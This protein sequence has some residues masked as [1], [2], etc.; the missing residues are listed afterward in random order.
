[1]AG[2]N[3]LSTA[4]YTST[5]ETLAA[6]LD[7]PLWVTSSR[8]NQT[9]DQP[10]RAAITSDDESADESNAA[11]DTG[12]RHRNK[13]LLSLIDIPHYEKVDHIHIFQG[14]RTEPIDLRQGIRSPQKNEVPSRLNYLQGRRSSKSVNVAEDLRIPGGSLNGGSRIGK[15]MDGAPSLEIKKPVDLATVRLRRRGC[16][17]ALGTGL[18][19]TSN[20]LVKAGNGLKYF[21]TLTAGQKLRLIKTKF[22]NG[23]KNTANAAGRGIAFVGRKTKQG[24]MLV[25]HGTKKGIIATGRGV[26]IVVFGT[27]DLTVRGVWHVLKFIG[28]AGLRG[29]RNLGK[30]LSATGKGLQKVG[31]RMET[32]AASRLTKKVSPPPEEPH[33]YGGIP[34]HQH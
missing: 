18:I 4:I 15:G 7:D 19:K 12:L 34:Q 33:S 16:A 6:H 24:I 11:L 10:P 14:W 17:G 2:T 13:L 27:I 25:L 32:S 22:T 8:S 29:F 1:M 20:G 5:M 3:R 28:R 31:D 9:I 21:D 30:G 23:V 26:F